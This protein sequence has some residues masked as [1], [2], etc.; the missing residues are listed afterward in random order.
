MIALG[1][2][3]SVTD[4]YVSQ[5]L[6]VLGHKRVLVLVTPREAGGG[7]GS[8]AVTV[9]AEARRHP[10]RVH[11]LDWVDYSAGH[12]A[13]FQPDRLHLTFAGARA[14]AALLA[15]A[16]PL[17]TPPG[18]APPTKPGSKPA[19]KPTPTP[20][21]CPTR[22]PTLPRPPTPLSPINPA[23]PVIT[24]APASPAGGDVLPT[25]P[26]G[27]TVSIRIGSQSRVALAGSV[28][29]APRPGPPAPPVV[30]APPFVPALPEPPALPASVPPPSPSTPSASTP[31]ARATAPARACILLAARSVTTVKVE[32]GPAFAGLLAG[33]PQLRVD[34]IVRVFD[35]AGKPYGATRSFLLEAPPSTQPLAAASPIGQVTPVP[36]RPQ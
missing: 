2:N 34:L 18:H 31:P 32:L 6:V 16:L 27:R 36:P 24:L 28:E 21:V 33:G 3:G 10:G 15:R 26:D 30:P 4:A 29:I 13:W 11:V 35:S 19:P 5:A 17:A 1:A 12:P 20:T 22:A 23:L 7:S 9:R 14:F 25:Q 8:D